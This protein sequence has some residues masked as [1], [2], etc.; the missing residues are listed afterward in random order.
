MGRIKLR[1]SRFINHLISSPAP[2]R[3]A[4]DPVALMFF[5]TLSGAIQ[6][7]KDAP[8]PSIEDQLG[9][10]FGL[11]WAGS[12]LIG[13]LVSLVGLFLKD[14][15]LGLLVERAGRIVLGSGALI[16]AVVLI[17]QNHV[18]AAAAVAFFAAFALACAY[19]V[20]HITLW[21]RQVKVINDASR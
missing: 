17:Y 16:Y 3:R 2:A 4:A 1:W 14:E 8:A 10:V 11:F 20:I 13:G 19:R 9:Y 7:V 5:A 21:L 15:N 18:K 6:L 12:L